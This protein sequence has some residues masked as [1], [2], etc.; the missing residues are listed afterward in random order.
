MIMPVAQAYA[1]DITPLGREG[2][3]M[4]II[5]A[6][7]S[8]GLSAGPMIGG[9][10]MDGFGIWAAFFGMG[11]VCLFGFVV[12]LFGLPP[13]S[14]ENVAAK[15]S[16]R[17]PVA[18]Q[19]LLKHRVLAGLFL[20][21]FAYML[22]VGAVWAFLPLLADLRFSM[23]S[24]SIGLLVMLSVFISAVI[25]VPMGMLADR[26]SR[27]LLISVGGLFTCLAMMCFSIIQASTGLYTVSVLI[28]IGGGISMPALMAAA[29]DIGH[30]NESMGSIMSF[31]TISH[32]LG[33]IIGPV[34]AGVMMDMVN[35][36]AALSG[37]AAVMLLAAIFCFFLTSPAKPS[38]SPDGRS[39]WI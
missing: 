39:S 20:F 35:L 13:T 25:M 31:I 2:K 30:E 27:R 21:R 26:M 32:S 4:G 7:V 18:F 8:G 37:G 14:R 19:A 6:S 24:F 38:K 11:M 34:T 12:C 15:S 22:C 33:M 1:G 17:S 28:G 16:H 3:A 36:S 10:L 29:V 23:S 9:L 5:N